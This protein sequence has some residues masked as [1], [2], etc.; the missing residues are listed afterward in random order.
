MDVSKNG[1]TPK[2]SILIGVSIINQGTPIF[3]NTQIGITKYL[4]TWMMFSKYHSLAS[5]WIGWMKHLPGSRWDLPTQVFQVM[6]GY[7]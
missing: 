6:E 3:G 5:F 1:G 4:L 2:S 7:D